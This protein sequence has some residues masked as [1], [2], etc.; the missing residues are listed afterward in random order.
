M[1]KEKLVITE[2]NVYVYLGYFESV[3]ETLKHGKIDNT[4]GTGMTYTD[5]DGI[6]WH[7][8]AHLN[9]DGKLKVRVMLTTWE[10]VTIG[11]SHYYAQLTVSTYWTN[12]DETVMSFNPRAPKLPEINMSLGY[13]LTANDL[14]D[15]DVDSPYSDWYGY[16]VGDF[17]G[18]FPSREKCMEVVNAVFEFL[19][20][21]EKC[22]L[23]IDE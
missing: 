20:D 5:N 16:E 3:R 6:E 14:K 12:E 23:I 21:T 1:E 8:K 17:S 7:S 15:K 19:F 13:P 4:F 22:E 18:R 9:K 11:A 10:G 2:D